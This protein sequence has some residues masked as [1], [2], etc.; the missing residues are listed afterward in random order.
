LSQ[1]APGEAPPAAPNWRQ[2]RWVR[3]LPLLV[4]A[5][6]GLVF[7]LPAAPRDVELDY[8]LDAYPPN[9]SGLEIVI[10]DRRGELV[11]RTQLNLKGTS[12]RIAQHARLTRGSYRLELTLRYPDRTERLSRQVEVG[13]EEAIEVRL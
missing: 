5:L 2:S 9:L 8:E 7:L 6:V 10:R 3:R 11:R 12:T 1:P 13:D 4:V